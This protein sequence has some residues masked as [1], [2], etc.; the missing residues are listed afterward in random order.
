LPT[1][2]PN[3]STCVV[4]TKVAIDSMSTQ[5]SDYDSVLHQP[6]GVRELH[7]SFASDLTACTRRHALL[8]SFE[9]GTPPSPVEHPAIV[10]PGLSPIGETH[11]YENWWYEGDVTFR[12]Q[13]R[14]RIAECDDYAV[15]VFQQTEAESDD[16]RQFTYDSYCELLA[17]I[18]STDHPQIVKIWN[19]L[20][21]INHG[22][23]D[24]E[25]YRQ[26]SIGRAEAFAKLNLPDEN[27]PTGTAI[28]TL[29]DKGLAI[30]VLASEQKIG[31]AENP[32][33]VSAFHY[34]RQYGP[35]SPK[36]SRAGFV[37]TENYTLYLISGT[38][39]VVGHKS[40]HPY[41]IEMQIEEMF[42]NLDSLCGAVSD[43]NPTDDRLTI[44]RATVV[45]AYLRDPSDI[46]IIRERLRN[47]LDLHDAN[48]VYL[49]GSICRREL[50]VEI[51]GVAIT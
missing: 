50:M 12:E 5:P 34:P 39:A 28:G 13:G 33:Q 31:L 35:K 21:G 51:D 14:I 26:F 44:D 42:K 48:V 15:A 16:Y 30:I 18:Q 23:E 11:R 29:R 43:L 19:Y 4:P 8:V 10:N 22:D 47:A 38:A 6:G 17:A 2:A 49:R 1:A 25:R 27:S 40:S 24:H 41:D 46:K 37:S 32:R 3:V 45:R 36:F 9:F 7:I 20:G